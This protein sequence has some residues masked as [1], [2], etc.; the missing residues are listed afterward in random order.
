MIFTIGWERTTSSYHHLN[1]LYHHKMRFRLEA[2]RRSSQSSYETLQSNFSCSQLWSLLRTTK[3]RSITWEVIIISL[4]TF[5][6]RMSWYR[7]IAYL[8]RYSKLTATRAILRICNVWVDLPL[9]KDNNCY[10]RE[11]AKIY[12]NVHLPQSMILSPGIKR[13]FKSTMPLCILCN[14][15]WKL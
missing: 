7:Y 3:Y 5:N 1:N 9:D 13:G 2:R 15:T 10:T 12:L 11:L 6:K 4:K 14:E 8:M